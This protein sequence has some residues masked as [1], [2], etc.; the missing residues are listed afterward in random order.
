MWWLEG[1]SWYCAHDNH[2]IFINSDE[3]MVRQAQQSLEFTIDVDY[4]LY[5]LGK[6]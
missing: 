6:V 3:E 1:H 5:F 2:F 4:T